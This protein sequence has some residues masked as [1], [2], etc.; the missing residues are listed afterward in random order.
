MVSTGVSRMTVIFVGKNN[1]ITIKAPKNVEK[2]AKELDINLESHVI[3]KNGEIVTPDEILQDD[4]V[5]E[6]ISVV[7]GG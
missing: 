6:I 4:D 7:S 1:Q 5:V 2:L 3:I